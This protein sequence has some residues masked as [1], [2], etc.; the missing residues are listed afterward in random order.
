MQSI[1]TAPDELK[2]DRLVRSWAKEIET[3][4][5]HLL[6]NKSNEADLRHCVEPLLDAFCREMGVP[7][8]IHAEYSM[9]SGIAD[10]VFDRFI[11]EYKR[12]TIL[13]QRMDLQT[14]AALDQLKG[15]L[16][17]MAKDRDQSEHLGG[18]VFDGCYI[19]FVRYHAGRFTHESIPMLLN[20]HSLYQLLFWLAH[21]ASGKALTSAN[22]SNDFALAQ[23]HTQQ[24]L[25]AL[26]KAL[27]SA[28]AQPESIV[29][30]LFEQWKLF[31]SES[32]DYSEA[33][34]GRKLDAMRKWVAKAGIEVRT[35][36]EGERFFFALHTY[37]ALLVKL[38]A[39][40]ALSRHIGVKIG[41]PSFA[42]LAGA[43]SD[44]LARKL[45]EMEEGGIFRAFGISNL[46]EGDFFSWYLHAW[47]P[48]MESA[49]R[50]LLKL[51]NQYE[52]TTLSI[53]REET[54]DLFK[55]LYHYLLPREIRHALGEYYTPDWLAQRLL[56]QIDNEYFTADARRSA[57][58]L[59]RKLKELRF[60]DPACGSGT[61]LVLIIARMLQL[62]DSLM[63]APK[64]LLDAVLRNVMGIDLNPLA[65]LTARVNYVLAI[66]DLLG[67]GGEITIPIY[68]A[69]SVRT[70]AEGEGIFG[71]GN[72]VYEFPTA[73]G[74]F[75]V[76]S[77]LCKPDRFN[78]FCTILEESVGNEVAP[79]SFADRVKGTLKLAE[80]E[81]SEN[82]ATYLTRL[83][84]KLLDYHKQGM[85]GLWARLLKNNFAPLTMGKF[86]YI[87]GNPP[88]VNWESL[89]DD[90]RDSIKP[91]WVRYGL[92]PHSG[93]DTILGKGK[94]DI[95]MLMTYVVCDTLLKTDGRLGFVVT[96]TLFKTSGAGQGFRR[97]RIPDGTQGQ[98]IPLRVVGVDD[99]AEL[100]PFEG[101][102]NRT[103]VMILQKG[104]PTTY[105]VHY[106]IWR[107]QPGAKFTYDSSFEDVIAATQR[108]DFSAQPIDS[109]DPTS[110]WFTARPKAIRAL[111]TTIGKSHYE[112]HA[113]S[114]TGGTNAVYWVE[115]LKR[116]PDGLVVIRNVT[117]DAK[118]KVDVLTRP[119]EPDLLFPLLRGRDVQRWHSEPSALIVMAQDPSKR[120]GI[121][122]TEM[123]KKYPKTFAYLKHFEKT[124]RS[125]AAFKRFFDPDRDPFYTMFAISDYTFAKWKVVWREMA[126][127]MTA[128]V[129]DQL[130]GKPIIPDHKL[131]MVE[132]KSKA[133]SHYLCAA[134]NSSPPRMVILGYALS[135]QMDT[136]IL[137]HIRIP[138]FDPNNKAHQRLS[139][140]SMQAHNIVHNQGLGTGN[141]ELTAVEAE[142][143]SC[144]A[145]LWGLTDVELTEI[146]KSLKELTE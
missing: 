18:V 39:W 141:Q 117:E 49:V 22:L 77:V 1:S 131:M 92:F 65:V 84:G 58:V 68:L 72:G 116:R 24:T 32:I 80:P 88:W 137:E 133:E 50:D 139:E 46:L 145:Q 35:P 17:D 87:V 6:P 62:G 108:A 104:K 14:T 118:I 99:M 61:F 73:I 3:Q 115:V 120:H 33:F 38:L 126:S 48:E 59:R 93:M 79:E 16:R 10:A 122:L 13:S 78:R 82:A 60:L 140:L 107:K 69:D 27:N 103:A 111:R 114:F 90:Y 56:N 102:T 11:I 34:G 106:S 94:K 31:F 40:L 44:L 101:A 142:V 29:G 55:K 67:S 91:L 15:Y 110:S 98:G 9:A 57:D 19:I 43:D 23:P 135:I 134:L 41:G 85:N 130:D 113:G 74:M 52:P 125:R 70:P 45:K 123:Q 2:R 53:R 54:R 105:P 119:L 51:L 30:K 144:A 109:E 124:L 26:A 12:P 47:N 95:S 129:V 81:W 97:F 132:C 121:A 100:N 75:F 127:V 36:E 37:F 71:N 20:E 89:P 83:Y 66:S 136:H 5:D 64:E 7:P 8:M 128:S 21:L 76:P 4:L 25:G 42:E 28:L 112:A 86:E 96:Q 138:R 146:Q 143:D 63:I